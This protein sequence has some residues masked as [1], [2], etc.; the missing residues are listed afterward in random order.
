MILGA[1]LTQIALLSELAQT[2]FDQPA[3]PD[4]IFEANLHHHR[5]ALARQLDEIV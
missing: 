2:D 1:N 3:Q 5:G 4:P